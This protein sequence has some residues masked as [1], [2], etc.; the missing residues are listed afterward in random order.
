MDAEDFGGDDG[1]DGEAVEDVDEC[2]PDFD[3]ASSFAFVVESVHCNHRASQ[4]FAT[5]TRRRS[6]RS[7]ARKRVEKKEVKGKTVR[8]SSDVGAFVI[9]SKKEE[10][11]GVFD[12]VAQEE[13]NRLETLFPAIDVITQEEIIRRRGEATHLEE[14][15]EIAVL[16]VDV[17][18]DLD[19]RGE[20]DEGRLGKEDFSRGLTDGGDF[21][22]LEADGFRDLARVAS[23]EEFENHL[24][25]IEGVL[26]FRGGGG[27][28]GVGE[29]VGCASGRGIGVGGDGE[30]GSEGNRVSENSLGSGNG[31]FSVGGGGGESRGGVAVRFGGRR[32]VGGG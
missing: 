21:D 4:Y 1:G 23:V 14:T 22:V 20:F 26:L 18:Y 3:V 12:L 6:S 5:G 2:F 31:D 8:T 30:G 17:S 27:A 11:F 24:V 32:V 25:D 28:E 10:V 29:V 13:E 7:K 9:P 15:N 19:G 16:S